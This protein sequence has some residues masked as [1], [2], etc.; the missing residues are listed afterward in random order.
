[1]TQKE[2]KQ[3]A[4][5]GIAYTSIESILDILQVYPPEDATDR[6]IDK[7]L[8]EQKKIVKKWIAKIS[9]RVTLFS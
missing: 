5:Q 7:I 1:M 6:D 2:A 9:K 8:T 4:E 3:Y